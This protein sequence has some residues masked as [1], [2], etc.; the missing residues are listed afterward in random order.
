MSLK[1][2][3]IAS[4]STDGE[5]QVTFLDDNGAETVVVFSLAHLD[6]GWCVNPVT[7][8]DIFWRADGADSREVARALLEFRNQNNKI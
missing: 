5:Y 1:I 2:K 4:T 3:A 6:I 7:K 8:T